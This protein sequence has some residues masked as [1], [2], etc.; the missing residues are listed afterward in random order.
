[1]NGRQIGRFEVSERI[2]RDNPDEVAAVLAFMRAVPVR[3][4]FIFATQLIEY[5]AISESFRELEMGT[6]I[7]RY[8]LV[9]ERDDEL[10]ITNVKA[11]RVD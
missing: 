10:N 1:M 5:T 11:M 9:V 4:E 6:M 8:T 2:V 7:P 3:A